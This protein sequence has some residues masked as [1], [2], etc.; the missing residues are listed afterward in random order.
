MKQIFT[1]ICPYFNGMYPIYLG[2]CCQLTNSDLSFLTKSYSLQGMQH[3]TKRD[4]L[5]VIL[6]V[7]YSSNFNTMVPPNIV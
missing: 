6:S 2:G 5:Y 1:L 7:N 4:N 3:I